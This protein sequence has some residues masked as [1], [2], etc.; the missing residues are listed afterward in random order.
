MFPFEELFKNRD[1]IAKRNS[2]SFYIDAKR[3]QREKIIKDGV[4][5]TSKWSK[6]I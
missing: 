5:G 3:A 6:I 4:K 1:D 2:K